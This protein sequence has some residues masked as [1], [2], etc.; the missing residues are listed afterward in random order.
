[1]ITSVCFNYKSD[2]DWCENV[3]LSDSLLIVVGDGHRSVHWLFLLLL[4]LLYVYFAHLC[5]LDCHICA[6]KDLQH[7]VCVEAANLQPSSLQ[8]ILW[9][10]FVPISN[11]LSFSLLKPSPWPAWLLLCCFL[12]L[13]FSALFSFVSFLINFHVSVWKPLRWSRFGLFTLWTSPVSL[14]RFI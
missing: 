9:F 4:L 2:A 8:S 14:N 10:L 5:V 1:M 6:G 3:G 7:S 12:P 11:L 13:V